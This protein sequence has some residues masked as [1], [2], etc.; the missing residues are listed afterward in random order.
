MNQTE[1]LLNSNSLLKNSK[2]PLHL[3]KGQ[4]W[5]KSEIERELDRE[6]TPKWIEAIAGLP[7]IQVEEKAAMGLDNLKKEIEKM[8]TIEEVQGAVNY[9]SELHKLQ[10]ENEA[11]KRKIN[12]LIREWLIAD[13]KRDFKTPFAGAR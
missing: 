6:L 7:I 3:S 1:A 4:R 9:F 10:R 5:I 13:I 8:E 12:E 2:T 11:L